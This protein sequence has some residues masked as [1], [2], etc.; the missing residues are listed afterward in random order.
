MEACVSSASWNWH[1]ASSR[2]SRSNWRAVNMSLKKLTFHSRYFYKTWTQ[3]LSAWFKIYSACFLHI[4]FVI[5]FFF[6][7]F[8]LSSYFLRIFYLLLRSFRLKCLIIPLIFLLVLNVLGQSFSLLAFFKIKPSLF[9]RKK[10]QSFLN[11]FVSFS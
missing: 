5:F 2:R 10:I 3:S 9:A 11:Y 6:L 1:W 7:N 8:Y 4:M